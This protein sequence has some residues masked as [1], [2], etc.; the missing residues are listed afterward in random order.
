MSS[1]L[2][3]I[4]SKMWAL[5]FA[6]ALLSLLFLPLAGASICPSY[7]DVKRELGTRLSP[8]SSIS[9]TTINAPRWS[10][11]AAPNPAFVIHVV[12]ESDVAITVRYEPYPIYDR[13]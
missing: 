5:A 13:Y 6:Y 9:N 7:G 4:C 3:A 11:Y 2:D 1:V 8:R 12:S 10:L